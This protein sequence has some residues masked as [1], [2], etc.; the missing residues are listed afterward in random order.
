MR[1]LAVVCLRHRA[2][3][4]VSPPIARSRDRRA[5]GSRFSAKAPMS[6]LRPLRAI[7][8]DLGGGASV[9][10]TTAASSAIFSRCSS[11]SPMRGS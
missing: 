6:L 1:V 4:L 10:F 11:V 3:G 7:S 8:Y 9:I 2:P 5:I